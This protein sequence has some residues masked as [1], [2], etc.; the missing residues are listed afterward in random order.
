MATK[1]KIAEGGGEHPVAFSKEQI[2]KMERYANRKDLLSVILEDGHA[3]TLER[4]DK[5]M[6]EFLK[7]KVK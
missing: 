2:L 5:R 4:V 6:E 7:G 3:F 1:K